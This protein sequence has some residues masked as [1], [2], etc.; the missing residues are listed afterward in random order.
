MLSN[1]PVSCNKCGTR[2]P[3][4]TG[5]HRVVKTGTFTGGQDYWRN[6]NLCPRCG[7]DQDRVELWQQ[8]KKALLVFG[9][10]AALL[11]ISA[12]FLF[13]R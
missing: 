5:V 4:N 10:I 1:H 7:E 6:V 9:S 11:G 2:I 8:A 13:V 3:K 12:Y